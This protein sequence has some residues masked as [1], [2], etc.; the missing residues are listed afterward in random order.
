MYPTAERSAAGYLLEIDDHAIWMDAGGGTWRN[1]GAAID[2]RN[3][4]GVVLSHRHPDHTVDVFMGFHARMFGDAVPLDPI[5][6]WAPGET[7]EVIEAFDPKLP[8]SFVLTPID[9]RS[10]IEVGGAR[11][12]FTKMVHPPETY[13][14]RVERDAVAVAYSADSGPDADYD[15]LAAGTQL[16]YCEATFQDRDELWSGHLRASQ[17]G[18]IAR[19]LSLPRLMLT[20]LP[21]GRDL[22]ESLAQ[23]RRESGGCEVQLAEDGQRM[24]VG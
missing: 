6:L 11:L 23:G 13:G 18:A 19:E 14:V 16:F 2:Y 10:E 24:V 21:P 12:T 5:P 15:R 17:A 3:V 9:E 4:E 7:L 8:Q 22:S 1:L 20:H